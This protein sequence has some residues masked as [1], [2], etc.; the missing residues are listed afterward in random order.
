M[1]KAAASGDFKM[2]N[3]AGLPQVIVGIIALEN[4]ERQMDHNLVMLE[5]KFGKAK[6]VKKFLG[7]FE[8]PIVGFPKIFNPG[9]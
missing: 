1:I 8:G 9:S 7:L 6:N 4:F 2:H 5:L 3:D